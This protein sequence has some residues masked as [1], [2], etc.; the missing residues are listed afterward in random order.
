MADDSKGFPDFN[1]LNYGYRLS[2]WLSEPVIK[3][4]GKY[5]DADQINGVSRRRL[6][7]DHPAMADYRK[8]EY[9]RLSPMK[10]QLD[11]PGFGFD[12]T[13]LTASGAGVDGPQSAGIDDKQIRR[14][15]LT[16]TNLMFSAVA[17]G[18]FGYKMS[19]HVTQ[20]ME[21][22]ILMGLLS[23]IFIL[24]AECFLIY[25]ALERSQPVHVG[26]GYDQDLLKQSDQ[27]SSDLMKKDE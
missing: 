13:G 15:V 3:N 20:V 7:D 27:Q 21:F 6:P 14:L 5:S 18:F 12:P 11:N 17:I 16:L 25:R 26:A 9:A 1:I 10:R 4:A 19:S 24:G 2:G 8:K 23:G 22:Q